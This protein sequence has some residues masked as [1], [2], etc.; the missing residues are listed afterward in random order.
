MRPTEVLPAEWRKCRRIP[1]GSKSGPPYRRVSSRCN[2]LHTIAAEIDHGWRRREESVG[3]HIIGHG[4]G[5]HTVSRWI[6]RCR[7][8]DNGR[9]GG[10]TCGS[11]PTVE[12]PTYEQKR[13]TED[14][15]LTYH[16]QSACICIFVEA[17][18]IAAQRGVIFLFKVGTKRRL[19]GV[20][21]S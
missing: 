10:T 17:R 16:S 19:L 5:R 15:I 6:C 13:L 4:F 2:A 9:Q 3:L 20:G 7:G 11:E 1:K 21:G 14:K 12:E 8:N 18:S